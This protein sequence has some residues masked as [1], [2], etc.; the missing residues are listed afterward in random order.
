MLRKCGVSKKMDKIIRSNLSQRHGD[1]TVAL[2][3][4]NDVNHMY[5]NFV[6]YSR[7]QY[8]QQLLNDYG[9]QPK[10]FHYYMRNKKGKLEVGPLRPPNG[11]SISNLDETAELLVE[12]YAATSIGKDSSHPAP[13][14][15]FSSH[16][17]EIFITAEDVKD[18]LL[19]LD[20]NLASSP[21]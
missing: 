3:A 16:M 6:L 12:T 15:V 20:V 11:H 8:Q 17:K 5:H 19:K 14:P 13:F 21:D 7:S 4:F 10:R 2:Q 1:V 18:V 9:K